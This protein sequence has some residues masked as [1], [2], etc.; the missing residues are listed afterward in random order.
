MRDVTLEV[1]QEL[2]PETVWNLDA[3]ATKKIITVVCGIQALPDRVS[4]VF[5]RA[6]AEPYWP[7][8]SQILDDYLNASEVTTVSEKA[9]FSKYALKNFKFI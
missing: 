2:F 3:E 8:G 9:K 7:G 5:F 1:W 6:G 4:M